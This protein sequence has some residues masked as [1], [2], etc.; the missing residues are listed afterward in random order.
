MN[1]KIKEIIPFVGLGELKFGLTRDEVKAF[2]G[3]PTDISNVPMM[4][5]EDEDEVNENLESWHYDEQEFSLVFDGDYDWKLVSIAI[6][7]PFFTLK[8]KSII[9]QPKDD[10]IKHF[11]SLG[12]ELSY[13]EDL[14]DEENEDLWLIESED[15]GFM[16]WF[17]DDE[18]IE[19]QILPDLAE[20]GESLV[21]PA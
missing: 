12:Y 9:G 18:V 19:M 2:L 3:K 5:G 10:V 7:D 16:V 17:Q 1:N 13:E 15:G 14:S 21:W 11:G 8:G 6:S 4:E 20:D